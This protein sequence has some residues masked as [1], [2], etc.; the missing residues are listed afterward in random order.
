MVETL[1]L[2]D[3]ILIFGQLAVLVFVICSMLSMGL[4]LTVPQILEPLKN[5][6]LVLQALVANF[7]LVPIVAIA[8]LAVFPLTQG[9]TIGLLLVALSAGAPFL[10]KLTQVAKGDPAF[11]VGLM[12]LLMVVTIG[13]LPL[14]L[15]RL[16][17]GVAINAW[18]IAR[19]LIFLML[20]P[21]F[22]G[23]LIR[24]RYKEVAAGLAPLMSQA[25]SL[26]LIVLIVAFFV[27]Y[28][29]DLA[30]V[31]GSTAIIASIIFLVVAFV[32][33][34]VFGGREAS[35]KRVMGLGTAQRNLGAATAVAGLNFTDPD[36]LVMVLVVG[37]AGL[38]VLMFIGGELGKRA[39]VALHAVPEEKTPEKVPTG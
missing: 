8:L 21:L 24:A 32:I 11:S 4:T 16:I 6:R 15:P 39:E 18:D 12:V 2:T 26:A 14:L 35:T 28:F 9:L 27:G 33:G 29:P 22:I 23:L 10:P 5:I 37:L 25:S 17:T 13:Y 1:S 30:G 19:S 20:I 34:Y 3:F 31:I 36:V 7:I 38:V